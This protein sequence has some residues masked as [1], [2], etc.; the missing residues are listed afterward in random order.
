MVSIFLE[1]GYYI[2]I[3]VK[4]ALLVAS[5]VRRG[6][7]DAVQQ[8][9]VDITASELV[10]DAAWGRDSDVGQGDVAAHAL[11]A[12]DDVAGDGLVLAARLAVHVGDGDVADGER[13]WEFVAQRQVL[14]AV[15][16]RHLD[17]VVDVV[18][19]HGVV[20]DVADAASASAALEVAGESGGRA[21]PDLDARAVG[22]VGHGNVVDVDVLHDVDLTDVLAKGADRDTVAAIAVQVLYNHVGAVG[23]ERD[24]VVSIVDHTVLDDNVAAAVGVPAVGVLGRGVALA[25]SADGDVVVHNIGAIGHPVVVLWRVAQVQV[26]DGAVV[27]TDHTEQDRAQNVDVPGVQVV[28]HLQ[29]QGQHW[30][31]EEGTYVSYLSITVKEASTV[32][33]HVVSSQLEESGGVLEDLLEGICLPVVGVVGELDI[34]LN[35]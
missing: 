9:L 14:L 34:S 18:D 33:V 11:A 15:A 35:V 5:L 23:L 30:R 20:G 4:E 17:R 28:P 13:G 6:A 29:W 12:A 22:G 26:R 19:R 1:F 7:V 24:T 31:D 27:Q 8:R 3:N 16:L 2:H 32:N 10:L 21:G 25:V